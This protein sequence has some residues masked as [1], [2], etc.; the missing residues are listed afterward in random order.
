MKNE[1]YK[2]RE[3][4]PDEYR[5][6]LP[7]EHSL[8]VGT[9]EKEVVTALPDEVAKLPAPD[10]R[11]DEFN[12][13]Q[14]HPT[15]QSEIDIYLEAKAKKRKK[16]MRRMLLSTFSAAFVLVGLTSTDSALFGYFGIDASAIVATSE[17]D[18]TE[19]A[20]ETEAA[21]EETT[22]ASIGGNE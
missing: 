11:R 19:D 9:P 16:R 17:V 18:G 13:E 21:T 12:V 22:E 5:S 3:S 20:I 10:I 2:R 7:P 15:E 14:G 1:R 8:G 4:T 6:W